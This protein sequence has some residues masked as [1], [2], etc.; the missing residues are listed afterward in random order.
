MLRGTLGRG[1][2]SPKRGALRRFRGFCLVGDEVEES[3]VV[4]VR[5]IGGVGPGGGRGFGP[6]GRRPLRV[7][8]GLLRVPG[9]AGA[10]RSVCGGGGEESAKIGA[11]SIL[12]G[13]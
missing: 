7:V 13:G 6:P 10:Q 4:L 8:A 1:D 5:G 3:L 12:Q 2:E 11:K 9:G